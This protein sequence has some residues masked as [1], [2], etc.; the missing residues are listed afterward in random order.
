VSAALVPSRTGE[1]ERAALERFARRE[2]PE[3]FAP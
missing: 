2:H 3:L 1:V